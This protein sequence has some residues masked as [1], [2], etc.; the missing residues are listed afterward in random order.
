MK[1]KHWY[2]MNRHSLASFLTPLQFIK[3]F[4]QETEF[5]QAGKLSWSSLLY[6]FSQMYFLG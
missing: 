2:N 5:E 6:S 4:L 1:T 3:Y